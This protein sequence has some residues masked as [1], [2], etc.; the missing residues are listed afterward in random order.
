MCGGLGLQV[1]AVNEVRGREPPVQ[2]H[3]EGYDP[4]QAQLTGLVDHAHAA[5]AEFLQ[6]FVTTEEQWELIFAGA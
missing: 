3:F 4:I 1:E 6:Q 2:E 5:A